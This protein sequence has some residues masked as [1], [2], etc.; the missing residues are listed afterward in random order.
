LTADQTF[1][2]PVAVGVPFRFIQLSQCH[3]G[4]P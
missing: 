3:I 2:K 1:R 4:L